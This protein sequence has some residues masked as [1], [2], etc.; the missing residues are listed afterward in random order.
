MIPKITGPPLY[1][2]FSNCLCLCSCPCFSFCHS[3]GESAAA[4]AFAVVVAFAVALAFLSVI[5]LGNLLLHLS[6][7]L[8]LPLLFFLSFPWGICCSCL[9]SC[10]CLCFSFCHSLGES[11]VVFHLSTTQ[12]IILPTPVPPQGRKQVLPSRISLLNQRHLSLTSPHL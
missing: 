2:C 3:L 12:R 8:L 10:S 1:S 6:W 11:A 4:V 5:P 9:C 7:S